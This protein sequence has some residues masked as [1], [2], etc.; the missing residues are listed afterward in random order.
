[1]N[2]HPSMTDRDADLVRRFG[3]VARVYGEAAAARF[4]TAHLCVIGVGGVGSWA[5]EAL[6]RSGVGALTLVDLDHVAESNINRQLHALG[7]TLGRAKVEVMKA[8]TLDINPACRVTTVEE[9]LTRDNL[10]EMVP[11]GF[12][13]VID[14]IDNFRVKAAL[15]AHCRRNRIRLVTIGGAGGQVDP[16]RIRVSDLSRSAQDPLLAR[17]RKLLRQDYGFS[18][19]PQRRFDVPCVWS[20][21]QMVFPGAD[22]GVCLQRPADSEARDLSCAGGI[23]SVVT[24][25]ATFGLVAVS[26]ALSRLARPT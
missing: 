23:G 9:F 8:R 10:G 16:T 14:C 6:A 22:G 19:N 3:G 4:A 1:M 24:V 5:V 11:A 17:V 26:H 13:Y 2:D 15:I 21:E 25:T 12:D 18:R 20:D 7:D